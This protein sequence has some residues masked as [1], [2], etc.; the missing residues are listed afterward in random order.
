MM[1][2]S[3]NLRRYR[4]A[5]FIAWLLVLAPAVLVS[6]HESSN[7][8]GRRLRGRRISVAARA[9]A[10]RDAL[11]RSGRI[12]AGARRGA[13]CRCH[14]PRTC[15]PRWTYLNRKAAEVPSVSVQPNPTQPPPRA[16]RPYVVPL[17]LDFNN[18]GAVDV[19]KQ[20]RSKVGIHGDQPGQLDNGRVDALRH[21]P[22]RARRRRT[23][24]HQTRHRRS[25]AVEPSDHLD[26]LA[27]GVRLAGRRGDPVDPR[28]PHGRGHRWA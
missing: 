25:R 3:S 27:R 26:R 19:A 10:A 21:R 7:L 23:D 28:H 12:P 13:A 2:L 4:W 5:V 9:A 18:S 17:K 6:L 1:R 24:E 8:T 15:A 20:L 22:G 11:P 16:D 14:R